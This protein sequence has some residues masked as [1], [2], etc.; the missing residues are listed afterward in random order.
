MPDCRITAEKLIPFARV[1]L[2]RAKDM[3]V[4]LEAVR[5]L[6]LLSTPRRVRHFMA[7][8]THETGSL[9]RLTESFAYRN[10]DHLDDIFSAVRG[11][12]DAVDLIRRG[13]EAIANRVYANRLGNGPEASGEGFRYRG[14]GFIQI[15]GKENYARA[16]HYTKLPLIEEPG[17][18]SRYR[19]AAII[20]AHYWR[21]RNVNNAADAGDLG[22]VTELV[23]GR[24]RHGLEDRARWLR[25]ALHYW[26]D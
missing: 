8:I 25:R 23:N 26:P 5:P 3:A 4:A 20:A 1:R 7:Q 9:T 22:M 12:A 24:A 10:P 15:T 19:E 14:R 11:R 16:A 17:L 2:E 21:T 6:A 13:P 18:A